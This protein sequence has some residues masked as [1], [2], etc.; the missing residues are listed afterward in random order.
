MVF[1]IELDVSSGWVVHSLGPGDR[2]AP[3]MVGTIFAL[4]LPLCL[5]P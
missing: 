4:R 5:G 3:D 2:L 1:Y